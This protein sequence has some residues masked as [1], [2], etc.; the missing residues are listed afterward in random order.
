[1]CVSIIKFI[2]A[3]SNIANLSFN[4]TNLDPESFEE[5]L[6]SIWSA[7]SPNS[8]WDF[9]LKLN[10]KSESDLAALKKK[11]EEEQ[12]LRAQTDKNLTAL[13][14]EKNVLELEL[15]QSE[16]ADTSR[17]QGVNELKMKNIKLE[18]TSQELTDKNQKFQKNLENFQ[19]ELDTVNEKL[20]EEI[21]LKIKSQEANEELKAL[22]EQNL[23]A[24]TSEK[25]V[26]ELKF[27]M[28]LYK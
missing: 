22:N 14:L 11:L 18:A 6:K 21:K 23:K 20:E 15:K 17:S 12:K 13:N 9:T 5:V 3:L 27:K 24:I 16:S 28:L 19:T 26:L 7:D 8:E 2:N 25:N 1:M 10:S 4:T